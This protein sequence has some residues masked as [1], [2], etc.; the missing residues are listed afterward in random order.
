MKAFK[1]LTLM[2][3]MCLL[4]VPFA[5]KTAY[6]SSG[7]ISLSDPTASVGESV[8][9]TVKA[10]TADSSTIGTVNM[11]LTYDANILEF[12]NGTS[13]TGEAGIIKLSGTADSSIKTYTLT[14][15]AIKSGAS[16]I[17]ISSYDIK[18]SK[19]LTIE[20][21]KVGSSTVTIA[22]GTTD[23]GLVS[24]TDNLTVTNLATE[25]EQT[26]ET[27]TQETATQDIEE[28][29]IV[30]PPKKDV[31]TEIAGTPFKICKI[32]E[33]VIP[34][35]FEYI[36]YMYDGVAVDALKKD[37]IILFYLNQIGEEPTILFL[38]D[39]ETEG[40]FKYAPVTPSLNYS[41]IDVDES[42]VIPEGFTAT[43][44]SVGG[45]AV[46]SWQSNSNS[47]YY[48]LY[49]MNSE[50]EKN[51]YLY[52]VVEKTVQ[53]YYY[54]TSEATTETNSYQTMY[55]ELISNYNKKIQ[56]NTLIIYGLI[57]LAVVFFF[58]IINLGLRLSDKR[59]PIIDEDDE[60]EEDQEFEDDLYENEKLV[61]QVNIED[62]YDDYDDFEENTVVNKKEMKKAAKLEKKEKAK[63]AKAAKSGKKSL[64]EDVKDELVI[65]EDDFDDSDDFE[66]QI[67]DLNDEK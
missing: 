30:S 56:N 60:E 3:L 25:D 9:V 23:S 45:I 8:S 55:T 50:G 17:K 63:K 7:T 53:R 27:A 49:L 47:E 18:D 51:V 15:N 37:N 62:D 6:A 35:G 52:D 28:D 22:E 65:G 13:A 66:F 2:I 41:V 10:T 34:E 46:D 61:N 40:F 19:S 36:G 4:V 33:D 42:V 44:V 16:S 29:K 20:M 1:K 24:Q 39:S 67:F 64:K 26:Q 59:H 32:P 31:A 48:L 11:E 58:I 5:G 43:E 21:S 14:F 54:T 38:Y 57:V 12:V